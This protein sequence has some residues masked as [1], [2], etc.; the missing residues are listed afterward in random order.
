MKIICT[1][2]E[3]DDLLKHLAKSRSCPIFCKP[4]KIKC[5]IK[6]CYDFLDKSIE[7]EITDERTSS[8]SM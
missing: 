7:W 8:I 3:K 1:N 4:Q 6:D 2:E 5:E